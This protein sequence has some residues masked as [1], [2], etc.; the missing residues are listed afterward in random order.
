M[1]GIHAHRTLP[2]G[3]GKVPETV[4]K[5]VAVKA[6]H[7]RVTHA[8]FRRRKV[9]KTAGECVAMEPVHAHVHSLQEGNPFEKFIWHLETE[10]SGWSAFFLVLKMPIATPRHR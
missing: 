3:G 6:V 1:E 7:R 10:R 4:G 9:A 2:F 5:S 8:F